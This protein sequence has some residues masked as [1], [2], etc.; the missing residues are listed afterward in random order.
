MRHTD[1][2]LAPSTPILASE[3]TPQAVYQQR[4]HWLQ[5]M[6]SGAA[7]AGLTAWAGREALAQ[8]AGPGKLA[9]LPGAKSTVAGAMSLDKLTR[10][11]D[12]S[13]YNNFYEFGTDK[14]DPAR[15]A[16]SLKPRPWTVA[17]EGE[18]G[19]PGS[20]D[21]DQL[22][23]LSPMEERIYRLRCVEGWSMVIPWVGYSLAELI[24]RVEPNSRAKYVEFISLADRSQMPGL[25]SGV[26]DWPYTE[27]LRID[28]A[29]HPL[30]LLAFGMYGEV[31]PNQNG[32]PVRLVLPW[33]YGFKSAKSIV[34]IRF[35][36]KQP[37]SSWTRAA[38]SEYGFYSNV[39]PQVDHPRWSQA[40]ERRIG[41]DGLFAKKRP[42]LMFNGYAEQV[43][44]LY[45]GMDLKKFY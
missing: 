9:K 3:I 41:E 45:A 11:E 31:L 37:V 39:N 27:G 1:R 18:V 4:R 44:S 2:H 26:L 29:M 8:T 21:L 30:S 10:Y 24:K 15:T 20:F 42:T 19:K 40:S 7:G 28:E 38:A 33:K 36:E 22:L 5:L 43:A 6:A 14:S 17:V 13:S 23:K 32:A 25:R 16:G 35:V 34:K 12:A